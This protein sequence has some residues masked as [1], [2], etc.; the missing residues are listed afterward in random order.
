MLMNY[1]RELVNKR[2]EQGRCDPAT[3]YHWRSVHYEV[4]D[5][6]QEIGQGVLFFCCALGGYL[7]F[8]GTWLMPWR[9][10]L[11]FALIA[12]GVLAVSRI[13]R[14]IKRR[15]TWP[16]TGY[17]EL[18]KPGGDSRMWQAGFLLLVA[19]VSVAVTVITIRLATPEIHDA[20]R[21]NTT[22]QGW[23]GHDEISPRQLLLLRGL[24]GLSGLM[25]LHM[26][27]AALG[28][29]RWKW[30]ALLLMALGPV[31]ILHHVPGNFIERSK[32]VI[33]FI[34]LVWLG[35]GGATLQSYRR[36][37]PP[38]APETGGTLNLNNPCEP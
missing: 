31:V 37:N 24:G 19:A 6:A 34:S 2:V 20:I 21:A 8:P 17:M 18:R 30:L 13:P 10:I 32:P 4:I 16:R 36:H 23:P 14:A 1:F 9:S 27:L 35:S 12:V 26:N 22:P 33:L 28:K 11:A 3:Q 38:V 15:L 5:G 7:S 25:Y 29:Q